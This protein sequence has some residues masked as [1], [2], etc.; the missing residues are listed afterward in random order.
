MLTRFH[1]CRLKENRALEIDVNESLCTNAEVS[2]ALRQK[3]N[4]E[5]Y[6][7]VRSTARLQSIFRSSQEET[8][9]RTCNFSAV[10]CTNY[11]KPFVSDLTLVVRR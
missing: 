1:F 9:S 10:R 4:T 7:M 2:Q 6:W 11:F 3:S 5:T 8:Y